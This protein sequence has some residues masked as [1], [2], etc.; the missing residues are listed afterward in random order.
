M[1]H[2]KI[3]D[4]YNS[5]A[6]TYDENRF[7]NSYGQFI[8]RQERR[9]LNKLLS[10][11]TEQRHVLE[12]A[13]GTGRLTNYATHALDASEQMMAIA[14][15]KHKNVSFTLASAADTGFQDETFDAVFSFHLMMHL[16]NETIESICKEAHRILKPGGQFIFDI[17]S[18]KRRELFHHKQDGWHGATHLSAD[19]VKQ[20]AGTRFKVNRSAGIMMMPVHKLPKVMRKPLVSTDYLLANSPIKQY[21]SYL[22]Y[23]L[24]KQ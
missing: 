6:Q 23:E 2:D 11:L 16:D 21:S 4:Y 1:S 12:I 7:G 5:L 15:E 8:D 18:R 9:V 20:L 14:Q 19:E 3:I 24:V 10:P 17:P 22:V 13:C